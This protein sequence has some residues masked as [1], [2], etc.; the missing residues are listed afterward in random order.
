MR[1]KNIPRYCVAALL[2]LNCKAA[3]LLI[4]SHCYSTLFDNLA[5]R[6][7][8]KSWLLRKPHL[9]STDYLM[10]LLP[11]LCERINDSFAIRW[12]TG[13]VLR[14]SRETLTQRTWSQPTHFLSINDVADVYFILR[15]FKGITTQCTCSPALI[16]LFIIWWDLC[17]V[18][19]AVCLLSNLF[20]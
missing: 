16:S 14:S 4:L 1:S 15:P 9:W 8:R 17:V 2:L 12:G 10:N 20:V 7:T 5:F 19:T 13:N 18:H 3:S 11:V 6:F